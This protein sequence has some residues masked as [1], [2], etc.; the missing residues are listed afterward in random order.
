MLDPMTSLAFSVH[1][2]KGVHA[3]LLGS[4]ISRS[5]DIMT[6]W[7]IVLDLIR[8][9]AAVEGKDCGD[10][11]DDWY[12]AEYRK[13][14]DYSDLLKRLANTS[15]ERMNLLRAYFEAD[16]A[17]RAAGKKEPTPA[18]HAVARLV[19]DGY[20][21]VIVTTNFDRLMERALE[22]AGVVPSIIASTNS[23][24]GAAPLSQSRCTVI[25]VHGDYLDT[26]LK[27]TPEELAKYDPA[28][29]RLLRQ[30]FD[31]YGLIV[32]GWSAEWDVALKAAIE[33]CPNRRYTMYWSAY[34]DVAR[35]AA[36]LCKERDAQVIKGMGA[37]EFFSMLADKVAVL[38]EMDAPHPLTKTMAVTAF[39]KYL[40]EDKYRIKLD[41]LVF[42][43]ADKAATAL[44]SDCDTR[45][46]YRPLMEYETEMETLVALMATGGYWGKAS[47]RK[48][49]VRCF[50]R[51]V[52]PK[53]GNALDV[54]LDHYP[55]Y[56]ALYAFGIAALAAGRQGNLA[57]ILARAKQKDERGEVDTILHR[58]IMMLRGG[59]LDNAI[60]RADPSYSRINL[61]T[62]RYLLKQLREPLRDLIPEESR[63]EDLFSR[64]EYL[65][66]L[67]VS[68]IYEKLW[69][70]F[71]TIH[72]MFYTRR[73]LADQI[74][75]EIE[76][77]KDRWPFLR[78]GLFD[79]SLDRLREAKVGFD[80]ASANQK[81][82]IHMF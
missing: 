29:K 40:V 71:N 54:H 79:G 10:K 62:S 15:T 43:E 33:G 3:L 13:E 26:R 9:F 14:P 24:L 2:G 32:C 63:Y 51:L 52:T 41:E 23:I 8:K 60:K 19:A 36:E 42:G 11:P 74:Q 30:V 64:F 48:L 69:G 50:Q 44:F 76:S 25:K 61:Q 58:L 37:D 27:N 34:R 56:L 77:Q 7:E 22:A 46:Q 80:K 1:S 38:K 67:V 4:G 70:S 49:W 53:T 35:D 17:D 65:V 82:Q 55:A 28:L 78:A 47:H 73:Y 57:Y 81:M 59:E 45:K 72:G 68:D 39:K 18:H 66:A 20:V 21:R 16:E 5:S 6:G 31:E 12:R 75:A